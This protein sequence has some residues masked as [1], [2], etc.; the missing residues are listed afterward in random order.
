[1][2][3]STKRPNLPLT[4]PSRIRPNFTRTFIGEMHCLIC[5]APR[6]FGRRD[7]PNIRFR[8]ISPPELTRHAD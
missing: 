7:D 5:G 3:S 4:M 8:V 1:V 2:R 6:R